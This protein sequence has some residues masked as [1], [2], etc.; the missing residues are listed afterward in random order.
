M[1]TS[2]DDMNERLVRVE[3]KVDALSDKVNFQFEKVREDIR[4]LGEGYEQGLKAI[5]KQISD[6]DRRWAEKW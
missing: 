6:M 4:K 1:A 3:E 5:S 2:G